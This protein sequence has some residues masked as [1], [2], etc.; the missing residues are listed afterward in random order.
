MLWLLLLCVH[1]CYCKRECV[2][3]M[4]NCLR[5]AVCAKFAR[6]PFQT[7]VWNGHLDIHPLLLTL[8]PNSGTIFFE[9]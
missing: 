3:C 2:S 4:L 1:S 9:I 7:Q 8:A 5:V 6:Y